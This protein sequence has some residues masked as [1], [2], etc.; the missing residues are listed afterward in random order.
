MPNRFIP[1]HTFLRKGGNYHPWTFGAR[2]DTI[3]GTPMNST[4]PAIS[5]A[6][7]GEGLTLRQAALIAGFA[8][9][10]GPVTYAEF[11]IYPKLVIAGNIE[12]TV[13]NLAAHRELFAVAI[14]CYLI[15][16]IEDIVIAWA[17]YVLLVPVNRALS[18]VTAWFDVYRDR[19]FRPAETGNRFFASSPRPI[20]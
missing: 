20:T 14:L 18:L 3:S 2:A 16:F 13:L 9:L 15:E 10:L 19:F 17:L 11:S 5:Q 7:R 12:Q 4:R 6:N 1:F 8:Y